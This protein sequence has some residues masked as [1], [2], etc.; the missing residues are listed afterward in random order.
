LGLVIFKE[1]D[2]EAQGEELEKESLEAAYSS[3]TSLS[4]NKVHG[5]TTQKTTMLIITAKP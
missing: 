2:H 1:L 5:V 4:A 3:E